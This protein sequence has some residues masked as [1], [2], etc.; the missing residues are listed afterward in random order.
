MLS[1][2]HVLAMDA[3]NLLDV[4]DSLRCRFPDLFP[5][6][7]Q[8]SEQQ[9]NHQQ[10]QSQQQH[11]QQKLQPQQYQQQSQQTNL[12]DDS[13]QIMTRQYQNMAQLQ[14]SGQ[15][16][17]DQLRQ[18]SNEQCGIYD[19]G[20]IINQQM[21]QVS[22]LTATDGSTSSAPPA[23]P[24]VAAKPSNFQHKLKRGINSCNAKDTTSTA[25]AATTCADVA[26]NLFIDDNTQ[27][28]IVEDDVSCYG[29][30]Q[31]EQLYSNTMPA[32]NLPMPVSCT[33]VHDNVFQ[34]V[35]SNKTA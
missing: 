5:K 35:M 13:Y 33:V 8:P 12:D 3:K 32:A 2:A 16:D 31:E 11:P 25:A 9:Q 30:E 15:V 7:N 21:E 17:I 10:Q 6:I 34:N 4:V 27:L 22:L 19:N 26:S 20:T 29:G 24:P 1:S 18:Y 23:K 28:R 14:E